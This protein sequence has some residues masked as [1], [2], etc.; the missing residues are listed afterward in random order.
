MNTNSLIKENSPYLLQHAHNPVNWFAWNDTAL[1]KAKVENKPIFLSIG[2]SVCHWCHVME[3]ESFENSEI[4]EI[5]NSSFISI[6]VD[7]EER[8]DIDSVYMEFCQKITGGGGWPLTVIMTPECKPFFI[9]TY[10]PKNSAYGKPGLTEVLTAV[11]KNWSKNKAVFKDSAENILK[12]INSFKKTAVP[13]DLINKTYEYLDNSFDSVYGGFNSYPKFP[14][15]P[16]LKFLTE[17]YKKTGNENA[18]KMLNT[19]LISMYKGGI[20]DHI[21]YGFSRYS[22]DKMWLV[23]HFE[24]MLYDNA[25]LIDI[26]I[27]AY[28]ISGDIL[29]KKIAEKCIIYINKELRNS[30]GGF[31]SSQD[32]D[33]ESAEGLFYLFNYDEFIDIL[34]DKKGLEFI[35]AYG[36]TRTGNFEGKNIPNLLSKPFKDKNGEYLIDKDNNKLYVY[37][38]NRRA[39]LMDDKVITSWNCFL[40]EAYSN[41]YRATLNKEYLYEAKRTYDFI[42]DKL[43]YG[44]KVYSNYRLGKKSSNGFLDDYAALIYASIS[45][46]KTTLDSSYIDKAVFFLDETVKEFLDNGNGGFYLNKSTENNLVRR[47]KEYYDGVMP[48]GN[49]LMYYNM[50]YISEIDRLNPFYEEIFVKLK[51]YLDRSYTPG[52][53]SFYACT[54]AISADASKLIA[55]IKNREDLENLKIK[56][57]EIWKY[58]IVSVVYP[59]GKYTLKNDKL[60]FYICK[61]HTCFPSSNVLS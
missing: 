7:K 33:S 30:E 61:N 25:L 5:L 56:N 39:L 50:L 29:F 49:S 42:I 32:A 59:N 60:T 45:L 12:K 41:M 40:I 20:F 52:G 6:K 10:L 23:P 34:G 47:P 53:Q 24:K 38:K 14:T 37:R 9:G 21:G 26:Y 22:T 35:N 36:I 3:R 2:Y 8:P 57:S 46:Y 48:S 43:T 28:E 17:Y 16:N 1:N 18:F 58:D 55:V 27:N 44:Q 54:S 11:Q 4:A 19:T 31:F 15:P 51:N 13:G